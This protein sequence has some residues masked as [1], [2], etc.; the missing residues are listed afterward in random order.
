MKRQ[1]QQPRARGLGGSRARSSPEVIRRV[2][3]SLLSTT[4]SSLLLTLLPP[5]PTMNRPPP[6]PSAVPAPPTAWTRFKSASRGGVIPVAGGLTALL[7]FSILNE[8]NEVPLIAKRVK[9]S[10]A[11]IDERLRG[12]T[13]K[14][15]IR[16]W[17]V[18]KAWSVFSQ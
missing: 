11:P 10:A 2:S 17:V 6:P 8:T 12:M 16:Q 14:E 15:L 18:Y 3:L 5:F 1:N 9:H 13:N 4:H 7:V